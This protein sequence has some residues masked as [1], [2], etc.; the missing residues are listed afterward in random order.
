[1]TDQTDQ[2]EDEQESR[3]FAKA[4]FTDPDLVPV[5]D[6]VEQK[7][8]GYVAPEGTN[9]TGEAHDMR[10]YAERLFYPKD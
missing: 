2:T 5:P 6:P 7:P 10:A 1:M 9:Q 8:P 4:L 3:A